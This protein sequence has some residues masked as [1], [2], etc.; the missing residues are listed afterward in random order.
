[1]S[2]DLTLRPARVE[3]GRRIWRLL[4]EVSGLE[5]NSCYAYLLLCSHFADS[6]V[7]AERAGE[8]VGFVLA[9]RPPNDRAALFVWQIGVAPAAR[10][11]GLGRQ[12]LDALVALP[13]CRDARFLTATV[14]PDNGPS[15]AL[16]RGF[17]RA[18]SVACE[19]GAGFSAGLFAEPHPDENLL[20]IG[21]PK[22]T[23]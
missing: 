6:C 12:L 13:A 17:A 3:D 22:G 16:F 9:Y 14:S 19:E 4:G 18:R 7:V 5:R 21:L 1:M 23:P 2:E 11:L 15:L 20:R 10:G 8:L